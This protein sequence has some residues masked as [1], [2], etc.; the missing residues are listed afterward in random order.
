MV[1][2]RSCLGTPDNALY[3]LRDEAEVGDLVELEGP[4]G[5]FR[6]QK[7]KSPHLFIA[8]GTGLAPFLS[9]LDRIRSYSGTKPKV[10]LNFGCTD[11]H[12]YCLSLD[13]GSLIWK[14]LA[15]PTHVHHGYFERQ[16]RA[17]EQ[18]TEP[19]AN[20]LQPLI[21][22]SVRKRARTAPVAGCYRV[23]PRNARVRNPARGGERWKRG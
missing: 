13:D 16:R 22:L 12:V 19:S 10:T 6:L 15:A 3:A 5:S 7:S 11:G 14:Y 17:L 2:G 23:A 21:R 4:F 18:H 20:P 1:G 9:M 8:G